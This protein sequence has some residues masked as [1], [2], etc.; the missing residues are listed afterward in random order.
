MD[1]VSDLVE[2]SLGLVDR[3]GGVSDGVFREVA[4]ALYWLE[5]RYHHTST[6]FRLRE[7]LVRRGYLVEVPLAAHPAYEEVGKSLEAASRRDPNAPTPVLADPSGDW[8]SEENPVVGYIIDETLVV[9]IGSE[10]WR[11][12]REAGELDDTEGVEPPED[13]SFDALVDAVDRVV[14]IAADAGEIDVLLGWYAALGYHLA[15]DAGESAIEEPAELTEDERLERIRA[16]ASEV[17]D[18]G[19]KMADPSAPWDMPPKALRE[20][21]PFLGWWYEGADQLM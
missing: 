11:G 2:S 14:E 9:E 19:M 16:R 20:A 13:D 15:Q 8:D 21:H 18:L 7:M 17:G 6:V 4:S 12:L 10:L 5:A 3:A 1:Y